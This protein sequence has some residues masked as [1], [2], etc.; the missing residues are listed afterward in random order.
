MS[1]LAANSKQAAVPL[2]Q[3]NAWSSVRLTLISAAL[4]A[5]AVGNS[6][7]P[8]TLIPLATPVSQ[9]PAA[10]I[11]GATEAAEITITIYPDIPDPRCAIVRPEQR[12]RLVNKTTLLLQVSLAAFQTELEP[13]AEYTF[14]LPLGEFL[15]PGVHLVQV[16]PCCGPEL[17]LK[18]APAASS[19]QANPIEASPTSIWSALQEMAPV[20]YKFPLPEPVPSPLDGTYTKIDPSWPQWWLCRRC[21][22]Y[23]PAGGIWK[24]QFDQG[25]MRIYYEV[26]GWRSFASFAL[27]EDELRIFNDVYCPDGVG[28]YGWNLEAGELVL[29]V[30][31]DSCSFGLRGQNLSNQSWLDCPTSSQAAEADPSGDISPGCAE[32]PAAP[33]QEVLANLPVEV[34]AHA[35]D[36]HHFEQP[37]EVFALANSANI[38]PPPGIQ[39]SYDP[40]S[41]PYGTTRV[42]WW[43]GDWIEATTDE[44][45]ASMGVQFWG[46]PQSGW[47]RILFDGVEVWRGLT[48]SLGSEQLQY[49]GYIEFS[50]FSPGGHT[51]RVES[52]GF[53]YRPLTVAAFGFS[54]QGGVG[55]DS[56]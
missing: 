52:L 44:D 48:S 55:S 14:D 50:G 11:C 25:V 45:F 41:I 6:I 40:E 8:A 42:L 34:V 21:A 19:A 22:D 4:S 7:P 10:G 9:E 15:A 46:A 26:T 24:L 28:R 35:G 53:D 1:S 12:L 27:A 51:I 23:R 54:E 36:S 13:G 2:L 39:V 3:L 18:P 29:N 56:P 47:A 5:C 30:I 49:G 20:A 17:W 31:E 37:P 32:N 38:P 33:I 16:L 43:G